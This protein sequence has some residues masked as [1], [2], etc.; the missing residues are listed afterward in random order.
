[1]RSQEQ[2]LLA[3]ENFVLSFSSRAS[4]QLEAGM[5]DI[6]SIVCCLQDC[7]GDRKRRAGE[8]PL[9]DDQEYNTVTSRIKIE[10]SKKYEV[11]F[12]RFLSSES[13]SLGMYQDQLFIINDIVR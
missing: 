5:I 2:F 13:A 7:S 10:T 9:T 1:M 12:S 8:N 3:C 6:A 4:F 11:E